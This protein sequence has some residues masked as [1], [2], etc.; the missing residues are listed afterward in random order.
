MKRRHFVEEKIEA[1]WAEFQRRAG[2][3]VNL[4]AG[5]EKWDLAEWIHTHLGAIEPRLMW[6]FGPAVNG[7]G[8]RLVITPEAVKHLRPLTDAVLARAPHLPDWEFYPYRLPEDLKQ[9]ELAVQGRTRGDLSGVMAR[10]A[11]GEHHLIDLVYYS[12]RTKTEDEHQARVDAFVTT[13]SLIGEERLDKW[14]GAIS[15]APLPTR[16]QPGLVSLEQLPERVAAL[17]KQLKDQ[18]PKAPFHEFAENARWSGF[19]LQP[20]EADDYAA[21]EDMFFG[22]AAYAPMWIACHSNVSFC[23]ERF[24]K[25]GETFCYAKVD[26]SQGLDEAEFADK[27][28]IEDA[29]DAALRPGKLGCHIGGGSGLRYSYIDLAL[30]DVRQGIAAVRQRLRQGNVPKRSWVL[31]HD[32]YLAAE[33]VG[34]YDDSPPPPMPDFQ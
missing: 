20:Q 13:E 27:I 11:I 29:L 14:I 9:V 10:A 18:L 22:K 17:V 5:K 34:I 25:H 6:E 24:S 16:R 33:W 19:E 15:A 2:P 12:P 8:H 4:F 28:E 31:F 32:D 30:L 26:G 3:I 7:T 21:Q 23:S 1:W